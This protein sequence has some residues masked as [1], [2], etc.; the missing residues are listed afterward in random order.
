[1]LGLRWS[2]I[3]LELGTL[4]VQRAISW[5]QSSTPVV[6]RPKSEAGVRAIQPPQHTIAAL[7]RWK[8]RQA[9]ERLAHDGEW[10]A[11]DAVVT[12]A[13]GTMPTPAAVH[14]AFTKACRTAELP[15]IRIH[16]LRH[17]SA[18]LLLSEGVPLP[19]VSA[20]LGHSTPAITAAIYSHA[21]GNEDARAAAALD[22]ALGS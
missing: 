5:P 15:R 3:D 14:W 6:V 16:D 4:Q 11:E 18:S 13:E 22:S 21:L 12:R 8:V 7:R 10:V 19:I 2:D 1:M 9:E 20:R 17:L